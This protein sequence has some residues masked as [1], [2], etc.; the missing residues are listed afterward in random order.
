MNP[1]NEDKQME[2][3]TPIEY[4]LDGI[5]EMSEE[6]QEILRQYYLGNIHKDNINQL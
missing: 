5:E 6:G 2:V 3:L 4:L 1:N